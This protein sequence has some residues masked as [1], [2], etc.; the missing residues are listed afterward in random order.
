MS[1]NSK[2]PNLRLIIGE[3]KQRRR[4]SLWCKL[5]F[6]KPLNMVLFFDTQDTM[7]FLNKCLRCG[8]DSELTLEEGEIFNGEDN[9]S[10]VD[11]DNW[12]A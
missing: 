2:P 5:G 7:V 6:H 3:K 12:D 8:A 4:E 9:Y 11:P 1:E 10:P